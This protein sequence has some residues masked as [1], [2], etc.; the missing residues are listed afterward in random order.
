MILTDWERTE[1]A[2]LAN[3]ASLGLSVTLRPVL[4][5]KLMVIVRQT[6]FHGPVGVN[7]YIPFE[8]GYE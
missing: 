7:V 1:L 5:Q 6:E 2:F 8:N 3:N 4:F